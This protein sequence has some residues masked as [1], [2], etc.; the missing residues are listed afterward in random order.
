MQPA[1]WYAGERHQQNPT[2]FISHSVYSWLDLRTPSTHPDALL[3]HSAA[4]CIQVKADRKKERLKL[5]EG[6]NCMDPQGNGC[7]TLEDWRRLMRIAKPTLPD[8]AHIFM[9]NKLSAHKNE[10]MTW[11]E[12]IEILSIINLRLKARRDPRV[13]VPHFL[14][15]LQDMVARLIERPLWEGIIQA[16]ILLYWIIFCLVW[17]NMSK[18]VDR[19]FHII[20]AILVGIF[21]L[22]VLLR[23]L[24]RGFDFA[25]GVI[26]LSVPVNMLELVLLTVTVVDAA[27]YWSGTCTYG[28]CST[29]GGIAQFLR[30][31]YKSDRMVIALHVFSETS[32]LSIKLITL[33][34]F[35]SYSYAVLGF[36]IYKE[37][38]SFPPDYCAIADP[39]TKCESSVGSE[40][41]FGTFGCSWLMVFQ[42]ITTSNW[43]D[44]MNGV[45]AQRSRWDSLF[46]I[47]CY[48]VTQ[49]VI[50]AL[51]IGSFID[52]FF[53]LTKAKEAKAAADRAVAETRKNL[54]GGAAT[55]RRGRGSTGG[56]IGSKALSRSRGSSTSRRVVSI[57]RNLVGSRAKLK[58]IP[59]SGVSGEASVSGEDGTLPGTLARGKTSR[60]RRRLI[61]RLASTGSSGKLGHGDGSATPGSEVGAFDLSGSTGSGSK[62]KMSP[63]RRLSG[64][65]ASGQLE[66]ISSAVADEDA[67]G[68]LRV[69]S[70]RE[71]MR[72][73]QEE[74]RQKR[75]LQR[76]RQLPSLCVAIVSEKMHAATD[77]NLVRGDVIEI[78]DMSPDGKRYKGRCSGRTG[79]FLASHVMI[80]LDDNMK[81][82]LEGNSEGQYSLGHENGSGGAETDGP[83][84]HDDADAF[85]VVNQGL[86]RRDMVSDKITNMNADEL[87][88]LNRLANANLL[89]RKPR[90]GAKRNQVAPSPS[91][92]GTAAASLN[93]PPQQRHTTYVSL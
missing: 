85:V 24:V 66:T 41:N 48:G 13:R 28:L 2:M 52:A 47:T 90:G 18:D 49:F 73:L 5:I 15:P 3:S 30:L 31:L 58:D 70:R 29:L 77:L 57:L 64:A 4:A 74:R 33:M 21:V 67:V 71:R 88:E 35:V 37:L 63:R 62:E 14:Q 20:T 8:A 27:L 34:T 46:F 89:A 42:I 7:I 38:E 54:E 87:F 83:G 22:D 81:A 84:G 86:S 39:V 78:S 9:F 72:K 11:K 40:G 25:M 79:W 59:Q 60:N 92:A 44:L 17:Q 32:S 56:T 68:G 23:M 61:L 69:D 91:G 93:N 51:M 43:H 55:L 1:R 26:V 45:I 16:L 65:A 80:V 53:R 12:F 19:A 36:E 82:I 75:K 6:F 50:L 10:I 76:K